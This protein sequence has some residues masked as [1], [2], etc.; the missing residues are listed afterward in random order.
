MTRK[1]SFKKKPVDPTY[2]YCFLDCLC[3][4]KI[5]DIKAVEQSL[6]LYPNPTTGIIY[7]SPVIEGSFKLFNEIGRLIDQGKIEPS[8]DLS[9]LEN[10]MYMLLL[11]TE[12]E[13][14]YFKVIK[15]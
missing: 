3:V 7:L 12:N 10:G 14:K 8:Y 9:S 11:Q 6:T 4:I 2:F 15:Q 5:R 1:T 13:S